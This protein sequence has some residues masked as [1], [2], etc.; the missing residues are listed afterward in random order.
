MGAESLVEIKGGG[1]RFP[2]QQ[3][4]GFLRYTGR[5]KMPARRYPDP[6][7]MIKMYVI[8]PSKLR[9]PLAAC[10]F[11]LQRNRFLRKYTGLDNHLLD[12]R[13]SVP[14]KLLDAIAKLDELP[15]ETFIC[16]RRPWSHDS[17]IKLIPFPEDLRIPEDVKA[18]GYEY[19]L[20]VSTAKE[21]L[22][23]FLERKPSL[24]QIVDFVIYY[25]EYDAYP[26][27]SLSV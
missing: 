23:G 21:I 26:E 9:F 15:D 22:E 7:I 12:F 16:A 18:Q 5:E 11:R 20:E 13:W 1:K 2:A 3:N 14:M 25:A 6:S 8:P 4:T 19:F 27:W 24:D 17:E 10:N